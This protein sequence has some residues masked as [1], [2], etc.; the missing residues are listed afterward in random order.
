[1]TTPENADSEDSKEVYVPTDWALDTMISAV[2]GSDDRSGTEMAVTLT[3]SGLTIT[4]L[5]ISPGAWVDL[6]GELFRAHSPELANSIVTSFGAVIDMSAGDRK[7]N[8]EG[9]RFIHMKDVTVLTGGDKV[10]IPVWRGKTEHVSGWSFGT[11]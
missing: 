10:H 7:T 11:I 1:M 3:L 2:A 4:G 6:A 5:M 8:P 9:R